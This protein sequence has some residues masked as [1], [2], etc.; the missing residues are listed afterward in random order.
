MIKH[1]IQH[2]TQRSPTCPGVPTWETVDTMALFRDGDSEIRV[3]V[4]E[5]VSKINV[6]LLTQAPSEST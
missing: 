4:A 2:R 3:G 5:S 6:D 1:Q